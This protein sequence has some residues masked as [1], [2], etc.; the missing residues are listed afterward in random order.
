MP[1]VQRKPGVSALLEPHDIDGNLVVRWQD[2]L[3]TGR[4]ASRR[5]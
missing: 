1:P 5:R 2:L 4:T 3:A